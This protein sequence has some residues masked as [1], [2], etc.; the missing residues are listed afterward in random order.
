[1]NDHEQRELVGRIAVE[2][3]AQT[4]HLDSIRGS[5]HAIFVL[6]FAIFLMTLVLWAK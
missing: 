6:V 2:L 4:Q 1:M 5:L 3:R